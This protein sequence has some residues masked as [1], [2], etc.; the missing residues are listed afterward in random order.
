MQI[1]FLYH[2]N[3]RRKK[4]PDHCNNESNCIWNYCLLNLP[5]LLVPQK[6]NTAAAWQCNVTIAILGRKPSFHPFWLLP[7]S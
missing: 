3:K 1:P 5:E 2:K 7:V 6:K 4:Q